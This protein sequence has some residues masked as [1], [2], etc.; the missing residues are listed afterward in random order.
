M[1]V[2]WRYNVVVKLLSYMG[3]FAPLSPLHVPFAL[4]LAYNV[5]RERSFSM[6]LTV[7]IALVS[8]ILVLI[9]L[10]YALP[11]VVLS[12]LVPLIVKVKEFRLQLLGFIVLQLLSLVTIF[13]GVGDLWSFINKL[14]TWVNT[15]SSSEVV[16]FYLA[17]LTSAILIEYASIIRHW[18]SQ[19]QYFKENPGAI[20]IIL[21]MASLIGAAILLACG[22][23]RAANRI[24]ELAYYYLVIGVVLQLVTTVKS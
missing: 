9:G 21:F 18:I 15:T 3:L 22:N 10:P 8:S 7:M 5:I 24:A 16:I 14:K 2:T 20:P 6:I 4:V 17:T 11:I 19:A 12:Y 1:G 13:N 23:E